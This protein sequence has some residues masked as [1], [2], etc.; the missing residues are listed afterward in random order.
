MAVNIW[1]KSMYVTSSAE[2]IRKEQKFRARLI[3][4]FAAIDDKV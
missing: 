1:S 3:L 4:N 2:N